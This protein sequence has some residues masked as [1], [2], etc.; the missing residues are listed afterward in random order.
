MLAFEAENS[1]RGIELTGNA[2]DPP[3]DW[4]DAD[5]PGA[6]SGGHQARVQRVS[7]A[8]RQ[9]HLDRAMPG[10]DGDRNIR[11]AARGGRLRR[12]ENDGDEESQPAAQAAGAV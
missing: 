5:E 4:E 9:A 3:E 10:A 12:G 7:H 6:R 8:R 1:R 2:G 11:P